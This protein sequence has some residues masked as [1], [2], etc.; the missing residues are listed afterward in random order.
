MPYEKA[1][2]DLAYD[3][4]KT[5]REIY[6]QVIATAPVNIQATLTFKSVA[7]KIKFQKRKRYDEPISTVEEII[8]LLES[9]AMEGV[10]YR[11]QGTVT[12]ERTDHRGT[13]LTYMELHF[14]IFLMLSVLVR[15]Y[16]S[17]SILT[18]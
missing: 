9:N 15:Y 2:K 5:T 12:S 17:L 6:N 1:M 10:S 14:L 3:T 4:I 8:T 18:N 13:D 16:L 7:Q 11:Y